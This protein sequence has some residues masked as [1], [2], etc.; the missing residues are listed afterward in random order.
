[1]KLIS[2]TRILPTTHAGKKKLNIKKI[3]KINQ[4]FAKISSKSNKLKCL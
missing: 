1:M 3:L 4:V 2:G